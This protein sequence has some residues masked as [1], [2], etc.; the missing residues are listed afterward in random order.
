MVIWLA[1]AP[2]RDGYWKLVLPAFLITGFTFASAAVP[3]TAQATADAPAPDKGLASSLFQT[4]THVGG[5]IVLAVLV[6]AFAARDQAAA[7]A[8]AGPATAITAGLEVALLIDAA[9][10]AAGALIAAT[11]SASPAHAARPSTNAFELAFTTTRRAPHP[12]A[13]SGAQARAAEKTKR[14]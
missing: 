1:H 9:L 4:F 5:A 12:Q 13:T 14:S 10:I 2:T 8:G 7:A 6:V 3:L 11:L